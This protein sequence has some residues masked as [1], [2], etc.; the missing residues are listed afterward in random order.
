MKKSSS[1][2]SES[3]LFSPA[4]HG[5][6]KRLILAVSTL[7]TL[8]V[9]LFTAFGMWRD[10]RYALS[11]AEERTVR[12]ARAA[13]EHTRRILEGVDLSL[14]QAV[15][16]RKRDFRFGKRTPE[17]IKSTLLQ[18]VNQV[19]QI[20]AII[21]L[22]AHG[23]CIQD[24]NRLVPKPLDLS[25]RGYFKAHG[26]PGAP[27]L[28]V[29]R[30][31][32][33]RDSGMWF[34]AASRR[35]EDSTGRF[36]GVATAIVEPRYFETFYSVLGEK[37]R[38]NTF[39]LHHDGAV[40]ATS[41]IGLPKGTADVGAD[42]GQTPLYRDLIPNAS[43][44]EPTRFT[45]DLFGDGTTFIAAISA[46]GG[47]TSPGARLYQVTAV[48][49][50]NALMHAYGNF[51]EMGALYLAM[52]LMIVGFT[53]YTLRQ[54]RKRES[55][56]QQLS[57]VNRE[58]AAAEERLEE[59]NRSLEHRVE[60]Q[61]AQLKNSLETLK[62][63]QDELI[64]S[65]KMASLGGLV[66]GVAHEINT[67]LGVCVTEISFLEYQIENMQS[68]YEDN[69]ITR[70]DFNKFLNTAS[71]GARGIA[72]SLR[73][74]AN[75]VQNFKQVAVDHSGDTLARFRLG[76]HLAEV[77]AGLESGFD[78]LF[79]GD[80]HAITFISREDPELNSYPEVLTRVVESL[81][82][83]S[84][85]HGFDNRGHGEIRILLE[86][87]PEGSELVFLDNG[88]G[89]DGENVKRIFD[90]FFTTRRGSGGTG[91]GLHIVYNLVTRKLGG[92]ISCNSTPEQGT[93]FRITLP[94]SPETGE[95]A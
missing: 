38:I 78:G 64:L 2:S 81:T 7:I 58:R 42:L 80:S 54:I 34:L 84:V 36:S 70:S 71:E 62:D 94:L 77:V 31:L 39:L 47:P 50:K 13:T 87:T 4:S 10:Y 11:T 35:I 6:L 76:T 27:S 73:H 32:Q 88:K 25:D 51:K 86:T 22:N 63:E 66:A 59:L 37:N 20:R 83:N 95:A 55:V 46:V 92:T 60:E 74:A 5:E 24:S 72:V 89:I 30:P 48:S 65:E 90:P 23:R 12:L 19:A 69:R 52:L 3:A 93:E 15:E 53:R 26:K 44:G 67:P 21:V 79:H 33:G 68:L 41:G 9:T 28:Y 75:L 85:I 40:I 49:R 57:L 17:E 82:E 14:Q 16:A 29:G 56:E 8:M 18:L 45:G 1:K 43:S 91:L 61:T